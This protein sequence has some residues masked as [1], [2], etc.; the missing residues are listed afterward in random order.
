M[1]NVRSIIIAAY[2]E[3]I[4]DIIMINEE[5]NWKVVHNHNQSSKA[6]SNIL[7]RRNA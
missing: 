4:K 6:N 3:T 1:I 7:V 2:N 5:L